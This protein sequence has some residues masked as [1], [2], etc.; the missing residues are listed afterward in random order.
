MHL[1][2]VLLITVVLVGLS[3]LPV[4]A[5]SA[6]QTQKTSSVDGAHAT[7]GA[8][9]DTA[10][11]DAVTPNS[12]MAFLKGLVKIFADVWDDNNNRLNVAVQ[13][14]PTVNAGSGTFTNQQSNV[15]VDADSGAGTQTL[16]LFGIA[17]P[18]SGGSVIGG[19]T[20]NPVIVNPGN[21]TFLVGDGSGALTVDGT[22]TVNAGTN[23]NTSALL[24][25]AAHD[26]AF[27]SAASPDTQVRTVQG[28]P[29]MTPLQVQSNS[30]NL[31]TE[32]TLASLLTSSNFAAAFG[33][34]GAPDSQVLS[35][36][37][38]A[39]MTPV[40]STLTQGGNTA[41]VNA[42]GQLVTSCANCVRSGVSHVPLND[43]TV[44]GSPTLVAAANANRVSLS[45]TKHSP[46]VNVRWGNASVGLTAG[47]RW[48]V[49][50]EIR[51]PAAVYM[52]SESSNVVFS[53]TEELQ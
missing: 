12:V 37:G 50:G 46:D 32:T 17:L 30:A 35:I 2:R 14:T 29:G 31:A 15:T 11:T 20:A 28:I 27:G 33:T 40:L 9:G 18:A 23:L 48:L 53:C 1:R 44:T 7:T 5:Q 49:A 21:G 47:Q 16:T 3:G 22:V 10:S 41:S 8:K 52:I 24:T 13:N 42:S 51:N 39:S 19:T 4:Q 43:V 26:A 25:T 34:P 45:C 36:Q 6:P 38:I